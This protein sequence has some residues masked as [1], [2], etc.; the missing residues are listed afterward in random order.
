M[1]IFSLYTASPYFWFFFAAL[2]SGA[3]FSKATRPVKVKKDKEKE[4][5]RKWIII[6]INF[7][8]ALLMVL[9]GLFIPGLDEAGENPGALFL[10][11]IILF[12]Y[13][14]LAFRFKKAIGLP[15]SIIFILL[16]TF[17]L[18]FLQSIIS[19]TGE[20][21]IAR[22]KVH[23][24]KDNTMALEIIRDEAE[25]ALIDMDGGY[26]APIVEIV[27]F[28]DFLVF[29]GNKTWYRFLGLTSF[30]YEKDDSGIR[31]YKQED[32]D[33][34]FKNPVGISEWLYTLIQ[35]NHEF[36]PGIKAVQV[37]IDLVK[38]FEETGQEP[39]KFKAYSIRIQ[40]DG[41]IQII[42]L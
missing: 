27:I 13:F 18:L 32:T 16:I 24:A 34:Y 29:F 3:A 22:I 40:N 26:F 9:T 37:E 30:S 15:S 20:T 4:V 1:D 5:D 23:Y 12:V 42:D 10:F 19:F 35:N 7:S 21:E 28:D 36:I 39:E 41:G 31:M 17:V 14:F 38:V 6:C 33:Y 2:F 25:P 8:I 11:F